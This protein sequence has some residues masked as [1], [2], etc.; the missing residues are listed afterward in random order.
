MLEVD[1][2]AKRRE[3]VSE[4][5]IADRVSLI[6]EQFDVQSDCSIEELRRAA[7]TSVAMDGLVADHDLGSLAYYYMGTGNPAN[8]D[9]IS[10]IIVANSLLTARDSS[11]RRTRNQKC[12]G[13]ENPGQLRNRRFVHRV[14]RH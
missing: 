4:P 13:N 7:R 14:L 3:G 11:G 6:H 9:A 12:S 5:Q 8:E 2:L 1:E 10:S